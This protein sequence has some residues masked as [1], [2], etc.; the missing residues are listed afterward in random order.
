MNRIHQG[1]LVFLALC[2]TIGCGAADSTPAAAPAAKTSE[3]SK[4]R[5]PAV[6]GLFYPQHKDDL[7]KQVDGFLA[8][9]ETVPL[10]RLRGLVCPHAGYDFSGPTAAIAYKQLAG[11]DIETVVV[12][13]PSHY[14][15]FEGAS[16]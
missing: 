6:A 16:A 15:D 4:T 13:A 14:A 2:I 1:L 10:G 8:E 5:E 12:L 9:A 11:R 3:P 7:S